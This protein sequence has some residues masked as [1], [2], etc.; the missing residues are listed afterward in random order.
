MATRFWCALF[1]INKLGESGWS[2]RAGAHSSLLFV[3]FKDLCDFEQTQLVVP[4]VV[5]EM[6]CLMNN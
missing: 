5:I 3:R 1:R 6:W 2:Y 4:Y